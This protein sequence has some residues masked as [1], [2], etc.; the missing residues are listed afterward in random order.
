MKLF[1]AIPL[2]FTAVSSAL[3]AAEPASFNYQAKLTNASGIALTG[4]HT[5]YVSLYRGGT[6][7]S[8]NSGEQLYGETITVIPVNGVVDF[9]VGNGVVTSGSLTASLFGFNDPIYVQLAVDSPGNVVLPRSPIQSV[10][11]AA[12]ALNCAPSLFGRFGGSGKDGEKTLVTSFY[13]MGSMRREYTNLTIPVGK[14]LRC[15]KG[16]GFIGV[17]G[18]CTIAGSI[19]A[20]GLGEPGGLGNPGS[21]G[22]GGFSAGAEGTVTTGGISLSSPPVARCA[23]GAGGG[24]GGSD[25]AGGP[26]GSAQRRGGAGGGA[27]AAGETPESSIYPAILAGGASSAAGS[28]QTTGANF[29]DLLLYLG[30]GGGAGGGSTVGNTGGEGGAGGGVIY[31]ECDELVFTGTLTARGN[32]GSQAPIVVP[33]GGGGGGGGVVL[34]RARKIVTNTG[35]VDVSGGSGAIAFGGGQPGGDGGPGFWDIVQVP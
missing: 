15:D 23:S 5:L 33:G 28:G 2:L 1:I 21:S 14:V 27:G 30:A 10:P 24:G 31:I 17:Q 12:T 19:S 29:A 8:A 7:D 22:G 13:L 16:W 26:G 3:F 9:A 25:S 34:V 35:T 18:V 4:S 11:F 20:Q 32:D 6:A